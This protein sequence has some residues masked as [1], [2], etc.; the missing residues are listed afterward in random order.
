M[1][2]LMPSVYFRVIWPHSVN[3]LL[4]TVFGVTMSTVFADNH[5]TC[6]CTCIFSDFLSPQRMIQLKIL[7]YW[8]EQKL[9]TVTRKSVPLRVLKRILPVRSL[10]MATPVRFPPPHL[11]R[12]T[13]TRSL[14]PE[15]LTSAMTLFTSSLTWPSALT[16]LSASIT[17]T[18][19]HRSIDQGSTW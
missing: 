14:V 18:S 3:L 2:E 15:T 4:A 16:P 10:G 8:K 1:W 13:T 5:P 17:P 12:K 7:V 9:H 11:L 6:T 19:G